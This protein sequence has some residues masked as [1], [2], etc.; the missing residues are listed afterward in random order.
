MEKCYSFE[1]RQYNNGI[2]NK[3]IDATYVIHLEDNGRLDSIN[4]QLENHQPT[5][6]V[7]VVFNKGY[8]KC[9]K[10]EHIDEPAK[11]I[12]N[13][14]L[15]V[16]TH[17]QSQNYNNILILED[18][19]LFS[20]RIKITKHVQEINNFLISN[21]QSD[22]QYLLGMVPYI[23]M[24][25]IFNTNHYISIMSTGA[26]AVIYTKKNRER[27]LLEKEENIKDWDIYNT[28]YSKQYSYHIPLCYQLFPETENRK[29]WGSHHFFIEICGK[30][31]VYI[32]KY[33]NLDVSVEPGYSYFYF[34][35]KILF[36]ILLFTLIIIIFYISKYFQ[37]IFFI[38]NMKKRR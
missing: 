11:D 6:V 5:N 26:H 13:A 30:I 27:I 28:F 15:N 34:F 20:D 3:S 4:K 1:K 21:I 38:K 9:K 36:F 24:P 8:K 29:K 17:A 33:F 31:C 18:D 23:M 12:T 32:Y 25:Y 10:E 35:S 22:I 14:F 2:F 19:F 7:Y 16:F 37:T